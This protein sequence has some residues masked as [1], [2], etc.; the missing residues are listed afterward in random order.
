[1]KKILIVLLF[2]MLLLGSVS[3]KSIVDVSEEVTIV[4][5]RTISE[6]KETGVLDN[7]VL[8][9]FFNERGQY[10]VQSFVKTLRHKVDIKKEFAV[11]CRTGSRT[12]MVAK[13]LSDYLK[14]K[15]VDIQG[16][17]M[18]IRGTSKKLVPYK[19]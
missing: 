17:I 11:I 18:S 3:L 6:Y 19:Y 13:F 1:M 14:L 12:K 2:P 9:P 8:I 16:G 7:S 15:V 4:D 5:I 10:D